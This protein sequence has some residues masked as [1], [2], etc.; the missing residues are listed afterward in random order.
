MGGLFRLRGVIQIFRLRGVVQIEDGY[1][2]LG[3]L[4]QI[5]GDI[6]IFWGGGGWGSL[7]LVGHLEVGGS[8]RLKGSDLKGHPDLERCKGVI[9]I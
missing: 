8:F 7:V 9:Q 5:V 3:G 1:S 2:N 4:I 6:Q